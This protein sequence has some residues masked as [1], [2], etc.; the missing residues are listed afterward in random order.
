MGDE[1]GRELLGRSLRCSLYVGPK[2]SDEDLPACAVMPF[3][4]VVV[5]YR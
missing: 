4:A 1:A 3:R 2:P 5:M